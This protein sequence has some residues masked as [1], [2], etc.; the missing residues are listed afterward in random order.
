MW[1]LL[2]LNLSHW[3][4]SF[5]T[6]GLDSHLGFRQ[7]GLREAYHFTVF[8]SWEGEGERAQEERRARIPKHNWKRFSVGTKIEETNCWHNFQGEGTNIYCRNTFRD[9]EVWP[10]FIVHRN[11]EGYGLIY[12]GHA[13]WGAIRCIYC[14]LY[15]T[16][17]ARF[18][19]TVWAQNSRQS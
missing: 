14:R 15:S 1:F 19:R 16:V 18:S 2:S 13:F 5:S 4:G 9:S 6:V 11:Q 3:I 17:S 12:C 7:K 10:A 8:H